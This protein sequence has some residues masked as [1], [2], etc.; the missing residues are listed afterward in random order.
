MKLGHW[1]GRVSSAVP[2]TEP[3]ERPGETSERKRADLYEGKGVD[4][5]PE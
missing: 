2:N 1:E 3:V 4:W 5:R